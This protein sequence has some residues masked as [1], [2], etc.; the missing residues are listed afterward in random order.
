MVARKCATKF[1][2]VKFFDQF[3]QKYDSNEHPCISAMKYFRPQLAPWKEHDEFRL[4]VH[5]SNESNFGWGSVN[6][7]GLFHTYD[8]RPVLSYAV[9][10]GSSNGVSSYQIQA[11]SLSE[12]FT[13]MINSPQRAEVYYNNYPIGYITADFAAHDLN[14]VIVLKVAPTFLNIIG[15][16]I[17]C[18]APAEFQFASG[19]NGGYNI[20]PR[21]DLPL[22]RDTLIERYAMGVPKS[23]GIHDYERRWMI[24]MWILLRVGP[25]SS[26][27]FP[28]TWTERQYWS[29]FIPDFT[30]GID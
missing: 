1:S 29:D 3:K 9:A 23:A 8:H 2:V 4:S 17:S 21:A 25:W 22:N 5:S 6:Q 20:S 24:A 16:E 19:V 14:G 28:T 10:G 18:Y 26:E 13:L 11:E 15:T 27:I 7:L 30:L 12:A